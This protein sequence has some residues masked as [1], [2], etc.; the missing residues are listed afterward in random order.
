MKFIQH[1]DP[2]DILWLSMRGVRPTIFEFCS[3]NEFLR[4]P[5]IQIII[6]DT[7]F[8]RFTICRG[9]EYELISELKDGK[10][11][12]IAVLDGDM[13]EIPEWGGQKIIIS[14]KMPEYIQ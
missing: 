1:I 4:H 10:T 8:K 12:K 7:N 11:Y 3:L 9:I 14:H 5:L 6:K 2:K 13:S